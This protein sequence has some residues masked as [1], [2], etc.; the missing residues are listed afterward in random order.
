MDILGVGAEFSKL[1]CPRFMLVFQALEDYIVCSR[2]EN[3]STY[4]P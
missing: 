3:L 1:T 4:E 2:K